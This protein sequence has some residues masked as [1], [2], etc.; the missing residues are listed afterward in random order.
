M[1]EPWFYLI[2]LLDSHKPI[3]YPDKFDTDE[4]GIDEYERMMS[5]VD[6]WIGKFLE[7][8]DLK[9]TYNNYFCQ[10]MGII[11]GQ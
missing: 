2:H 10:I 4:Y 6:T 3:N 1:D 11:S 5:Y 9:N 8:I 7:K